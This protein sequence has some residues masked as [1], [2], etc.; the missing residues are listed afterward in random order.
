MDI[1]MPEM[2]GLETTTAI[3][4]H[5]ALRGG[6]V[7][8]IAVTAHAMKGAEEKC[9]AAGMDGYLSKP[10]DDARLFAA[11]DQALNARRQAPFLLTAPGLPI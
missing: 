9:L 5:E 3:R 8:I 6:H 1:Q 10:I 11:I 4:N 7:P 2:D